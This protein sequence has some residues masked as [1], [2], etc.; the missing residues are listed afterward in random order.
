METIINNDV[1]TDAFK[2]CIRF[3]NYE[4]VQGDVCE[5]GVYTGRSLA[6]LSHLH[7]IYLTNENRVNAS[8]TPCRTFYGFDSWE[9]LPIDVEGHPRWIQGLFKENHSYHPTITA[10]QNVE[11][12][13]IT[14][15]FKSMQLDPPV[16]VK[17]SYDKL[18]LPAELQTIALC[19]IDC[20]LY[21]ST[22]TVLN[23]IKSKLVSGS[24]LM[25][26]DWFNYKGDPEKGEQRAFAEFLNE[27][28]YIQADEFV[29]YATFCKAFV[30]T[31]KPSAAF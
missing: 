30:L 18:N 28:P 21:D 4:I 25:F 15:F 12:E 31:L 7:N 20:D 2:A 22:K 29:R 3:V 19:H 8:D 26:D 24:I 23:L 27:N 11:P 1:R 16:L 5:F 9:G 13:H 17:S 14:K 10:K 6:S